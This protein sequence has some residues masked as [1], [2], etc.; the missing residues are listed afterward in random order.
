MNI[1]KLSKLQRDAIKDVGGFVGGSLKSGRRKAEN[2]ANRSLITL[3]LDNVDISVNDIWESITMLND[4]EVLI[5]STHEPNSPRLRLIIPLERVVLPDEYQA[6]SRKIAEEIGIDMF[7]D[8]TYEP[9]RLMY[10]P[11]TAA[12]G[13]YIFKRQA[14]NWLNPDE[15]LARYLDWRD[16][17]FGP[18]TSK[19]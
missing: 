16:F 10:W 14:G 5:Y 7:D 1:K 8:T 19:N 4:F 9:S 11:S 6:I 2:L 17:P 15:V 12:D 18:A 3:D 13:E